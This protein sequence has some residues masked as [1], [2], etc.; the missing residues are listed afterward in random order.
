MNTNNKISLI[1]FKGTVPVRG[2][3]GR[4]VLTADFSESFVRPPSDQ[5]GVDQDEAVHLATLTGPGGGV[6][7]LKAVQHAG[8][9]T[10]GISTGGVIE[11]QP[12]ASADLDDPKAWT[13]LEVESEAEVLE[14]LKAWGYPV[15]N[16]LSEEK[17]HDHFYA[18]MCLVVGELADARQV[19]LATKPRGDVSGLEWLAV[20]TDGD[21]M[22]YGPTTD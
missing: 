7:K 19:A 11:R 9:G 10:S 8:H 17:A 18:L 3:F 6:L 22:Y 1:A 14:V 4:D 20:R 15:L 13:V 12:D 16:G 2:A 5:L 21:R